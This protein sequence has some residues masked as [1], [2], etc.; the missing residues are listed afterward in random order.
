MSVMKR[1]PRSGPMRANIIGS[2]IEGI[3]VFLTPGMHC[4]ACFLAKC[5]P[6]QMD[7]AFSVQSSCSAVNTPPH[8][9][10]AK[11]VDNRSK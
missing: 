10:L 8:A 6:K 11:F 7:S 3:P 4:R 9:S 2:V 5:I 1:C